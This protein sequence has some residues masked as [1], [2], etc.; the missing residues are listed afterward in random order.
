MKAGLA[1]IRFSSEIV[2]LKVH[3][4]IRIEEEQNIV[5][6]I[7]KEKLTDEDYERLIPLLQEK[8]RAF[9]KIRWYFEMEDFKGWTPGAM[10]KDLK[11]DFKNLENLEK[12]AMVG[13]QTWEKGLTDLMKPF[14]VA[15][16]KFFEPE[17][18]RDAKA[19]IKKV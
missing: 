10:W 15:E 19:W 14:T 8:I 3:L 7:A 18:K 11:F 1:G 12:I 2:Q 17:E 9:G 6:S 16:I 5:Y 4:M 13:E